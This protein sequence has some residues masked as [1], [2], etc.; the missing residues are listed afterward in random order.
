ME[1]QKKR[2]LAGTQLSAQCAEL[3][4]IKSKQLKNNDIQFPNEE[5]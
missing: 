3:Q 4:A 2:K 1:I 5:N